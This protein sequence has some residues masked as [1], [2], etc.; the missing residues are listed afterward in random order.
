MDETTLQYNMLSHKTVHKI[1]AKIIV[2]KTEKQEN[3]RISL[4]NFIYLW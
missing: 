1:G 4:V 3:S 2:I